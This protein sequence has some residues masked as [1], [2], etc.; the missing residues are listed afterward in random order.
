MKVRGGLPIRMKHGRDGVRILVGIEF[1]RDI[2]HKSAGEKNYF[3][4]F[5]KHQVKTP[6]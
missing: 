3:G 1:P 6:R 4:K 5:R 2:T